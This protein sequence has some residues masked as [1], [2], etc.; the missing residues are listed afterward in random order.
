MSTIAVP[1]HMTALARANAVR[2]ARTLLKRRVASGEQTVAEVILEC[3]WEAANMTV[4]ELLGYQR[5]WATTRTN[6]FLASVTVS[7]TRTV[8][9]LTDRQRKALAAML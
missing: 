2:S 8:G 4:A 9:A 5:R 6:K 7:E 3:P 1:Q